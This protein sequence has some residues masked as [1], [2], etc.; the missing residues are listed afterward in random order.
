MATQNFQI[1]GMRSVLELKDFAD[2][3]DCVVEVSSDER[4]G[5]FRNLIRR[6]FPFKD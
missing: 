6:L 3:A 2:T 5:F 4:R 1:Q